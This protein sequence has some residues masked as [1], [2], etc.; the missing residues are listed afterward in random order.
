MVH[1]KSGIIIAEMFSLMRR[2]RSTILTRSVLLCL[3]AFSLSFLQNKLI[4]EDVGHKTMRLFQEMQAGKKEAWAGRDNHS[5]AISTITNKKSSSPD[6]SVQIT[7]SDPD[8]SESSLMSILLGYR[9]LRHEYNAVLDNEGKHQEKTAMQLKIK[10]D[11]LKKELAVASTEDIR[12]TITSLL[13][14]ETKCTAEF[15]AYFEKCK[16]GSPEL[17][18]SKMQLEECRE[19]TGILFEPFYD[20]PKALW[21]ETI[22]KAGINVRIHYLQFIYDPKKFDLDDIPSSIEAVDIVSSFGKTR[23]LN[24]GSKWLISAIFFYTYEHADQ[25]L[26]SI[27]GK[28][29][30]WGADPLTYR[31]KEAGYACKVVGFV[32]VSPMHKDPYFTTGYRIYFRGDTKRDSIAADGALTVDITHGVLDNKWIIAKADLLD[33]QW[34]T[35]VVRHK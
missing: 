35:S 6:S 13:Q 9:D 4:A 27:C 33:L 10:L 2:L 7:T 32:A 5:K 30:Y 26:A 23:M 21:Q 17:M 15:D 29:K 11:E 34:P 12:H 22:N 31:L 8:G 16:Y 1:A 28:D 14:N 19:M 3:W 20:D 24:Y 25:L 18:R